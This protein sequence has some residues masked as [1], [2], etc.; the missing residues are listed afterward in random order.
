MHELVSHRIK[1]EKKETNTKKVE[2][3][4]NE[5]NNHFE[6]TLTTRRTFPL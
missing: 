1:E 3:I 4:E 2:L 5:N 6:A